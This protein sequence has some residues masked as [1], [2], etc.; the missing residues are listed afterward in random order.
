MIEVEIRPFL[1]AHLSQLS[2]VITG[3]VTTEKYVVAKTESELETAVTLKLVP[4]SSPKTFLYDHLDDTELERLGSVVAEGLSLGAF[5]GE[6]LVGVALASA[7]VWNRSLRVWEFH[8]AAAWRGQ[9][10]GRRLMDKVA[11]K[12][13][14]QNLRVIVCETQSNNV[15]AIRAY[16]RL[17]FVLDAIDLSFYSNE[18]LQKESVAVFMKRKL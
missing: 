3:Y 18:D 14:A 5:A 15:P 2:S 12:A 17:G 7:E 6:Q 4:L 11:E 9:G 1:P 16:R 8:V 13:V 10:V